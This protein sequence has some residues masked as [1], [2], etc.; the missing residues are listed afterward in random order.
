M[1]LQ[2]L[3]VAVVAAQDLDRV[4]L[5]VEDPLEEPAEGLHVLHVRGSLVEFIGEGL[6]DVGPD[7]LLA[8]GGR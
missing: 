7:S 3:P 1:A 8:V 5:V 2:P 6:L 4:G